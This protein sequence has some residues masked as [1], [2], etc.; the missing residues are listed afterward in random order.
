MDVARRRLAAQ[1]LARPTLTRA[2]D[3]VRALGA[4]QSQD[5]AGGVWAIGAR[6]RDG[7]LEDV[8]RAIARASIV[9]TWPMRGTLHFVPAEDARW[10]LDLLA[11]RASK[12]SEGRRRELGLTA[13]TLATSRA[14]LLRA[15][16]GGRALTRPATYALLEEHGIKTSGQRGIHIL[17][18]HAHEGTIV[19]GARDGKQP[20]FVLFDEWIARSREPPRAKALGELAR[21]YFT[22]HGPATLAD[23][24]W[25]TG[26]TQADA[27][28]AVA[29]AGRALREEAIDGRAH[30]CASRP[31]R[32]IEPEITAHLLPPFDELLVSYKDR[33][34]FTQRLP[35][36]RGFGPAQ[37]LSPTVVLDGQVVGTW[38]RR[39]SARGVTVHVTRAV[40]LSREETRAV[41]QA[42]DRY[43]AFLGSP[44]VVRMQP[45]QP[46]R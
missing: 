43:G 40:R 9:R 36:G 21:R 18:H 2:G 39:V 27:R 42:G 45:S 15:L 4:V 32:A 19:L 28:A 5:L 35:R 6:M 29:Q 25:W 1:H 30:W 20:T 34:A 14:L 24:A 44:V 26:L 22:S 31:R 12:R 8:E 41:E 33:A 46:K 3:V 16:R 37:L 7:T 11:T 10:M 13:A 17:G 38:T 23:L